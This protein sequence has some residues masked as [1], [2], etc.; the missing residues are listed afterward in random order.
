M[1]LAGFLDSGLD[2]LL[3]AKRPELYDLPARSLQLPL[4]YMSQ[5]EVF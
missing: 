5:A 3:Q 4:E 1:V 2:E